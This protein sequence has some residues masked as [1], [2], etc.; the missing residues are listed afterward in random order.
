MALTKILREDIENLGVKV[1]NAAE[2]EEKHKTTRKKGQHDQ[3]TAKRII[4][5][6]KDLSKRIEDVGYS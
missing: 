2:T 1:S 3:D 4:A 6:I 5:D